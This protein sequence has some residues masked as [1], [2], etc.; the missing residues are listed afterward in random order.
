MHSRSV[1]AG[2]AETVELEMLAPVDSSTVLGS[3]LANT[4][5]LKVEAESNGC[6][7]DDPSMEIPIYMEAAH[8]VLELQKKIA[9]PPNWNPTIAPPV[10]YEGS[11]T[12]V[13]TPNRLIE[14]M[15]LEAIK[16]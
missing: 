15:R 5:V 11:S 13:H 6:F 8:P 1:A 3:A 12:F 9:P 2:T 10:H 4:Y 16:A 7:C 14:Q